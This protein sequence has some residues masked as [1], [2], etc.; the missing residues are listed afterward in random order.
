[1]TT[2]FSKVVF[3]DEARATLDGKDGWS[4][5]WVGNGCASLSRFRRP[6]G[7]GGIMIW[8]GIIGG[9]MVRPWRVSQE[10]KITTETYI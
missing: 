8:V 1:M 5:G 3:T 9:I 4:K 6:Q 7:G 10:I 2:N